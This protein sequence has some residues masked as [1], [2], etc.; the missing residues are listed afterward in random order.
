MKC[1][2]FISRLNE[3]NQIF[4]GV[5]NSQDKFQNVWNVQDTRFIMHH[6]YQFPSFVEV[7]FDTSMMVNA[8]GVRTAKGIMYDEFLEMMGETE[9]SINSIEFFNT[10]KNINKAD[11][12]DIVVTGDSISFDET[13]VTIPYT[14]DKVLFDNTN[15]II[16]R[17][18]LDDNTI[19]KIVELKNNPFELVFDFDKEVVG[20]NLDTSELESYLN[21]KTALK[22]MPY[23]CECNG[24]KG[25]RVE[26]E[27]HQTGTEY[28]YDVVFN[29]EQYKI[30]AKGVETKQP[31][32][33]R[34][35]VRIL[36]L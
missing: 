7:K 1:S 30:N 27:I 22:F 33:V 26:V 14:P 29:V 9:T 10:L 28:M 18:N 25:C 11:V 3:V 24:S 12:E 32:E 20:V 15:N 19:N 8:K 2:D 16:A 36:E 31:I 34:Y 23:L 17:F 13:R 21:V 35:G 4:K 5:Y 6:E